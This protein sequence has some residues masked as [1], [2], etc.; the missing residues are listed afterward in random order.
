MGTA[1]AFLT[2]LCVW[3]LGLESVIALMTDAKSSEQKEMIFN[4]AISSP[5]FFFDAGQV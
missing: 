1:I 4:Q 5:Y 3:N 2:L